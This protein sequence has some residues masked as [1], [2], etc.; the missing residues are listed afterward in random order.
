MIGNL[1]EWVQDCATG[2]YVGRPRDARAWEWLGGCA[3]RVQR[4]GSWLAPTDENR[5]AARNAAPA[6]EHASDAGFRVA[7]DLSARTRE[8]R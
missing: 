4:G 5:S 7:A 8:E 3:E 2:S 1:R 6:T